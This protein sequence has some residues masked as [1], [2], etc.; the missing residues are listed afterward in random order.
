M[1][2]PRWFIR[3]FLILVAFLMWETTLY[4]VPA[5]LSTQMHQ[6]A[7]V[8]IVKLAMFVAGLVC[9]LLAI[10]PERLAKWNVVLRRVSVKDDSSTRPP[11]NMVSRST[12]ATPAVRPRPEPATPA[13]PPRMSAGS[14]TYLAHALAEQL[15]VGEA[16]LDRTN[17]RITDL[18]FLLSPKVPTTEEEIAS[19]EAG[20]ARLLADRAIDRAR[21]LAP[22]QQPP[23]MNIFT[24]QVENPLWRRVD[25]RVTVL[26]ELIERMERG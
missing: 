16:L 8:G 12:A 18:T 7:K 6:A 5:S 17:R 26:S 21:F 24:I 10:G 13:S 20:V 23:L 2:N 11:P 4:S 1:W 3:G 9:L 14:D 15:I 22:P 19:W 25:H